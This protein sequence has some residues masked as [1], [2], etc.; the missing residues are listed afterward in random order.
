VQP[1]RGQ[2]GSLVDRCSASEFL[3]LGEFVLKV[4][5]PLTDPVDGIPAEDKAK[6]RLSRGEK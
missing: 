1:D 5:E 4:A 6:R 2:W 3:P